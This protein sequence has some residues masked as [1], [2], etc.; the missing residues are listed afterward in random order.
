MRHPALELI[1]MQV[2]DKFP[3]EL[4]EVIAD[5]Y[6]DIDNKV[7]ADNQTLLESSEL[8]PKI[9]K[10]IFSRLKMRVVFDRELHRYLPAAV[11]PFLSDYLTQASEIKKMAQLDLK[12][13]FGGTNIFRHVSALQKE[14]EAYLK[15]IHNRRGFVDKKNARLGGYLSDVKN[16]L[17][18]D[19]FT[20]KKEE[21]S[22]EQVAAVII[23]ELGHAFVG[24]ESHHRLTTTNSTI[25]DI[26][27]K[28][29]DNDL[30]RAQYLFKKHFS[31]QDLE[32]ASL[33]NQKEITDFYGKL[34][35][36]YLG[37]LDSQLMNAKYD[38]TNF[39]NLAD[40][41]ATRFGVGADLV[42]GLHKLHLNHGQVM[43][44]RRSL[45]FTLITLDALTQLCMLMS[46]G[47]IAYMVVV[48]V[49]TCFFSDAQTEMTYDFPVERY[50][51]VQQGI[52][53]NLKDL[54]LPSEVAKELVEQYEA[55]DVIVQKFDY[56]RGILSTLS[57]YIHFGARENRQYIHLQQTIESGLS[58]SLFVTSQKIRTI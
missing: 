49:F 38:E 50:K 21:L 28:I 9:E 37:E 13:L 17:I 30:D 1:Q 23:H 14:K 36:T 57:D 7:Y 41:F 15:R 53:N 26:F 8:I 25:A 52:A 42:S 32:K 5:I 45:W 18:I 55:I 48:V 40:S 6:R 4:S 31:H 54:S 19:F 2:K 33:G 43:E 11:I 47:P 34:A 22:P 10:L 39:E 29:N 35:G 24:L 56:F 44:K 46:L 51:R 27:A 58:N 20:L 3:K 12:A 16:I